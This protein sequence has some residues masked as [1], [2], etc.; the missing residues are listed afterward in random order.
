ML[1][2][3]WVTLPVPLHCGHAADPGF[4]ASRAVAGGALVVAGDFDLG[5]RAADCLPETDVQAVFEIGA[6]LRRPAH[7]PGRRHRLEELA[8]DIFE[9]TGAGSGSNTAARRLRCAGG[10]P[11]RPARL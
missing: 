5:L 6:F 4:V 11:F 3:I 10:L 7:A 9:R 8:E 2:A 1:P